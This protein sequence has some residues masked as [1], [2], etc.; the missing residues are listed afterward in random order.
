[1]RWEGPVKAGMP[2][3]K[4][5]PSPVHMLVDVENYDTVNVIFGFAPS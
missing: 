4:R 3:S 1:M 5:T 2:T